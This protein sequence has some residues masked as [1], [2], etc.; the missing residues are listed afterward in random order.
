MDYFKRYSA[1]YGSI[2]AT[3]LFLWLGFCE[4]PWWHLGTLIMGGF[5]VL[6]IFDVVQPRHTLLRNYPI[7]AHFRWMFEHLRPYLR[8]YIVESNLEGRPFNE[9]ERGLIYARAKGDEDYHPLGTELDL[10]SA[11][12]EW[13]THSMKPAKVIKDDLRVLVGNEQCKKPYSASL[14]NISAMSFGALGAHAIEALNMGAKRG[15]FYH[16]TGEGAISPYHLKHGGDLVWELGTGY[17]GC[18]D[19]NGNFD[20]AQFRDKALANSVKM[21]EIKLNQGA[22]P[23]HGGVL[24]AAKITPEIA[25]T[26]GISMEEDCV[27]PSYHTA[28]ST[29]VELLEFAAHLRELSDGKPVGI[30][31]CVGQPHEIFAIIKAMLKTGIILD[32]MVVDGAE[33]GTGAAPLE[34]SDHMGMPLREG[35]ILVRN[36]LVGSNLRDK[37]R[38]AASGK[39]SSA[40]T[41]ASNCAIGADW[42][43]AARAFMF[44]LGCIMSMKCHTN[45]CPTGITTQDPSRQKGLVVPQKALRVDRFHARTI[46]TLKELIAAAGLEHTED[47]KPTHFYHRISAV[48]A[49]TIDH[50]Y[51]FLKPGSLLEG[52]LN[53]TYTRWWESA[54]ADSFEP[55]NHNN[56]SR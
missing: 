31:F 11:Q 43:N 32:Y 20:K 35:L 33:G 54:Q 49:K 4:S 5:A 16:D 6:G 1:L 10:Y 45:R 8:Q 41:I 24:P 44:A 3:L 21:V 12:S 47:L 14:L 28:F 34:F 50:I 37:V 18:R 48:E 19:K 36:A 26:R 51:T 30:K 56:H 27:S 39:V 40:F 23:G 2:L 17:F 38:I 42:C 7:L 53:K 25:M 15:N 55:L 13:I 46:H 52:D 22:K 9:V 29:P